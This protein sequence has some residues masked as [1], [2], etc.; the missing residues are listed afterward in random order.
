MALNILEEFDLKAMGELETGTFRVAPPP[1]SQC[2]LT[3]CSL[4]RTRAVDAST[5]RHFGRVRDDAHVYWLLDM[6]HRSTFVWGFS[7]FI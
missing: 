2:A 7:P 3:V 5:A 1:P 6:T 4:S